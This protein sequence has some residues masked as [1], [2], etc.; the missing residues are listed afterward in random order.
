MPAAQFTKIIPVPANMKITAFYKNEAGEKD[1]EFPDRV[2]FVG[3]TSE[4][5]LVPV[6]VS[7]DGIFDD[8]TETSN[9]HSLE[10]EFI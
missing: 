5:F 10:T 2:A 7:N 1:L 4:G 3:I 6:V 9:F 8:P